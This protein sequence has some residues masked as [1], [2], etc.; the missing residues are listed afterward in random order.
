MYFIELTHKRCQGKTSPGKKT[1]K[2][3]VLA[4]GSGVFF[5]GEFFLEHKL[6]KEKTT[7][8]THDIYILLLLL[9][10]MV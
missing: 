7:Q 10:L 1:R 6:A 9:V 2:G 3:L 4:L 5:P 8:H